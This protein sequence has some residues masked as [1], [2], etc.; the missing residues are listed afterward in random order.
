MRYGK[1]A[2]AL[3]GVTMGLGLFGAAP[4]NA[5]CVYNKTSFDILFVQQM[6]GHEDKL[7]KGFSAVVKPGK[8]ACC[9]W[10]NRDC[11]P[12]GQR[13]SMVPFLTEL[14]VSGSTVD[15][16]T[17]KSIAGVYQTM[18]PN[19]PVQ[20]GGWIQVEGNPSFNR[21]KPRSKSNPPWVA[22]AF[23]Y[24]GKQRQAVYCPAE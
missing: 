14:R 6:N 16:G 1:A 18:N 4:A 20:A 24:D 3:A 23:S 22:Y 17:G 11:N 10:Q 5:F 19:V 9:N 13:T 2:S 21:S 12:A 15:C 8:N 7:F